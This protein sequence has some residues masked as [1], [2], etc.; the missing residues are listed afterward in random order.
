MFVRRTCASSTETRCSG[1]ETLS[2][3][4]F[5]LLW[6]SARVLF[7]LLYIVA[8][9][10]A[11]VL[12]MLKSDATKVVHATRNTVFYAERGRDDYAEETE[13][14]ITFVPRLKVCN[15]DHAHFLTG[16]VK[17][18]SCRGIAPPT[19]H[20]GTPDCA[21]RRLERGQWGFLSCQPLKGQRDNMM[22]VH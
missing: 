16:P 8:V 22:M 21:S 7:G 1:V 9:D 2:L 14:C 15:R 5:E 10:A 6:C 13:I 20:Y 4:F 18:R 3:D 11:S 17:L 12:G 19:G